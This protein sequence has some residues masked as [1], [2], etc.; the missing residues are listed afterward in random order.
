LLAIVAIPLFFALRFWSAQKKS[1]DENGTRF[2]AGRA[3]KY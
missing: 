2:A 3:A 1:T